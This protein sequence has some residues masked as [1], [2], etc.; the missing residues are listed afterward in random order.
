MKTRPKINTNIKN[1]F[2]HNCSIVF[3]SKTYEHYQ[4]QNNHAFHIPMVT[5]QL[6][7]I[8]NDAILS[9]WHT[10]NGRSSYIEKPAYN[11][12]E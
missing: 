11:F 12:L 5:E 6:F 4:N 3:K 8:S 9:R 10:Q 2:H 1:G 7:S